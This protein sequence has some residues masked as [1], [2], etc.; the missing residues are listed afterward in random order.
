MWGIILEYDEKNDSLSWRKYMRI[1]VLRDVRLPLKKSKKIKKPGEESKLIHFKYERL[2]TFCY[3]CGMLGHDENKC[4]KLFDM[5]TTTTM[6][7][8][9]PE[10]T[11]KG[12]NPDWTA[13]DSILMRSQGAG[14]SSG[15]NSTCIEKKIKA[16]NEVRGR[17]PS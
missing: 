3:V 6:R 9:G 4:P 1:R 15:G 2:G 16:S 17:N 14:S 8:W 12:G 5:Q 11:A 13:P 7:G 10:L